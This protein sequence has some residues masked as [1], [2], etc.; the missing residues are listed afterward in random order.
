MKPYSDHTII[1]GWHVG[2]R[3]VLSML[4]IVAAVY[5]LLPTAVQADPKFSGGFMA[6]SVA[7]A[8]ATARWYTQMLGF[9][10]TQEGAVPDRPIRFAFLANGD[11]LIEIIERPD[12]APPPLAE[13]S[14]RQA[15]RTHG[16]FKAGFWTDDIEALE[17]HLTAKGALFSH[18]IVRPDGA[19]Y[20]TLAVRDPEGNIVQIF[21]R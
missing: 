21:G 20:R 12:A 14:Q 13:N 8:R 6:V 17:T 7:D 5:L 11:S 18:R 2:A 4:A 15:W 1:E 10:V 16:I 9:A 19:P 3:R